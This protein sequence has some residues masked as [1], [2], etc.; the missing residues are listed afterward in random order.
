[1]AFE[2]SYGASKLY[3]GVDASTCIRGTQL[4]PFRFGSGFLPCCFVLL[5][6][7]TYGIS[8]LSQVQYYI[9]IEN[10]GRIVLSSVSLV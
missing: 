6:D 7:W 3:Y 4:D 9:N 8:L 2:S 1:M 10:A 5:S